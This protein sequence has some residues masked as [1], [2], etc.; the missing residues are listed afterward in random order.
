[1]IEKDR[2]F[3][4]KIPSEIAEID[5]HCGLIICYQLTEIFNKPFDLN[6]VISKYSFY[7][8]NGMT[9]NDISDY[10]KH[11]LGLKVKS[12][13]ASSMYCEDSDTLLKHDIIPIIAYQGI[14]D[15]ITN[16]HGSIAVDMANNH[17][18]MTYGMS[19]VLSYADLDSHYT[20]F[21]SDKEIPD[22]LVKF[23]RNYKAIPKSIFNYLKNEITNRYKKAK[24]LEFYKRHINR[25]KI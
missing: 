14:K 10:A 25:N 2:V 15:I 4:K 12:M 11:K 22:K 18:R 9:M 19:Q 5:N 3:L 23:T 8:Q 16:P 7:A 21:V 13:A 17:F 20:M 1:M 6:Y 24:V